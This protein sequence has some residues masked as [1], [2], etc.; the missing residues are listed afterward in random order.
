MAG[1]AP[2][3]DAFEAIAAKYAADWPAWE[4]R[5]IAAMM[6]S[7]GY[8]VSTTTVLRALRRRGLL[9]PRGYRADRKSWA[10]LRRR[11]FGDH[12]GRGIGFGRPILASSKQRRW[13]SAP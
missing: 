7:D 9:L 11:V 1:T 3:V 2:N 6:R 12:P 5:K 4:H 8:P 10:M 13:G